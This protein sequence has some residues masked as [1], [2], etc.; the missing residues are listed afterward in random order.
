MSSA[1]ESNDRISQKATKWPTIHFTTLGEGCECVCVCVLLMC[2]C[3]RVCVCL[4]VCPV[5]M[6][7]SPILEEGA[8]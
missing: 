2:V 5:N 4:R 8:Q 7:I 6:F 1:T 3:E